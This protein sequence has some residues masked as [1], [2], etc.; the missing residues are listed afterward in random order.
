[1]VVLGSC[2]L[3][4]PIS[5]NANVGIVEVRRCVRR[6][7]YV[8]AVAIVVEAGLLIKICNLLV[9]FDLNCRGLVLF[10][11]HANVHII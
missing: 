1:M 5:I 10:G 3:R 2:Y 11:V 7:V 9:V 4:L 6:H 8:E